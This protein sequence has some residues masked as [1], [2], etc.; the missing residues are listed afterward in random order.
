[1]E[2]DEREHRKPDDDPRHGGD[3]PE[4]DEPDRPEP[5]GP[6]HPP[7]P[8][9]DAGTHDRRGVSPRWYEDNPDRLSSSKSN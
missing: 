9:P 1:M 4:P 3:E 8:P 5:P 6:K 7:E 2:T